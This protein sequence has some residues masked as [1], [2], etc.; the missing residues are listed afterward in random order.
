MELIL[1]AVPYVRGDALFKPKNAP[2]ILE[3]NAM[4][5]SLQ[6][7]L[8][9]KGY[10]VANIDQHDMAEADHI[11]FVDA[12]ISDPWF[13]QFRSR[14]KELKARASLL[15][16]DAPVVNAF[17]HTKRVLRLFDRVLTWDPHADQQKF[18]KYLFPNVILT[19][20]PFKVPYAK[21]KFLGMVNANKLSLYQKELYSE[22]KNAALFFEQQP[23]GIDVYG[24][25]WN[26]RP[27]FLY[28]M[29]HAGYRSPY[30]LERVLHGDF[31]PFVRLWQHV[32][33]TRPLLKNTVK[34]RAEG[35]C[36]DVYATYK[37]AI[38]FE[39]ARD[40]P[41]YATEK[42]FNCLNARCVPIY[43][44]DREM[45]RHVPKNCYIDRRSFASNHELYTFLKN[46]DKKT[47]ETYIK[48]I[49]AFL[50]KAKNGPFSLRSFCKTFY[51]GLI[52]G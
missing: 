23:E 1:L 42:L 33:N 37:F 15:I 25:G 48:N 43:W 47:Y 2:S 6:Q 12:V 45:E 52:C 7:Y 5:V 11:V 24:N 13:K 21:K 22:R 27:P 38:C 17:Q 44:G 34:G 36:V 31:S 26:E 3:S 8:T 32:F 46:I 35:S 29:M 49:N 18:F 14:R 20:D 19:T 30:L 10:R 40:I 4:F 41:G 51:D 9:K 39:N 28:V 50:K 16:I